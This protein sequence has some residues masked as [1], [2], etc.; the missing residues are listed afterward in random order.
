MRARSAASG[1]EFWLHFYHKPTEEEI[2]G[3][4]IDREP[5]LASERYSWRGALW[6][7]KANIHDF[8]KLSIVLA[9]Y[10]PPPASVGH[11]VPDPPSSSVEPA[12]KAV[13]STTEVAHAAFD[14]DKYLAEKTHVTPAAPVAPNPFDKFDFV[15]SLWL[16]EPSTR[17]VL[18]SYL[19][20]S[21]YF[22]GWGGLATTTVFV[23]FALVRWGWYFSLARLHELSSAIRAK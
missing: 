12:P 19:S 23:L 4:V 14:P 1:D 8:G 17:Y 7:G 18:P 2:L 5:L 6:S 15:P 16:T 11:F 22:L 21:I 13:S 20:H 10:E 3:E 9:P